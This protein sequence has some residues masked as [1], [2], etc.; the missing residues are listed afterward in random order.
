MALGDWFNFPVAAFSIRRA[1]QYVSARAVA[2]GRAGQFRTYSHDG[3][4]RVERIR[5]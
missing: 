2:Y 3:F 5:R 4:I 1:Q